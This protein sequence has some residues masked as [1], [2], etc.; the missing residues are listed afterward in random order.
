MV[1]EV[2]QAEN[3]A[4]KCGAWIRLVFGDARVADDVVQRTIL[5]VEKR[6]DVTDGAGRV[7]HHRRKETSNGAAP[8]DLVAIRS[9]HAQSQH[10]LAWCSAPFDGEN[11]NV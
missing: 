1:V 4:K 6:P 9:N 8:A 2:P 3:V 5:L 10:N 7:G 11:H